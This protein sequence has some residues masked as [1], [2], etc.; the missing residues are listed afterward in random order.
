MKYY[1]KEYLKVFDEA[2]EKNKIYLDN[3]KRLK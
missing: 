3:F 2:V 1:D